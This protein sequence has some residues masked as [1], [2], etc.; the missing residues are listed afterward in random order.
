MSEGEN[1]RGRQ[2]VSSTSLPQSLC[3]I[4]G[5]G[6]TP[7]RCLG[8]ACLLSSI[9]PPARSHIVTQR[10]IARGGQCTRE[11]QQDRTGEMAR[12]G[13]Q[14][15]PGLNM[16]SSILSNNSRAQTKNHQTP[17]QTSEPEQTPVKQPTRRSQSNKWDHLSSI[18][19]NLRSPTNT[20]Q[21]PSRA[22]PPTPWR[23]AQRRRDNR[24]QHKTTKTPN[25]HSRRQ[26]AITD[27][28]Q[29]LAMLVRL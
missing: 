13:L 26:P 19:P 14:G 25:T 24:Q 9:P 11:S 7:D 23:K 27:A 18:R 16:G 15:L 2:I 29:A 4:P 5:Q 17:I 21:P 6:Q 3:Q 20:Q 8:L 10:T 22:Q 12:A 28:H 1:H